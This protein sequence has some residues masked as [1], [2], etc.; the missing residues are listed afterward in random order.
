M[1]EASALGKRTLSP[2]CRVATTRIALLLVVVPSLSPC[3]LLFSCHSPAQYSAPAGPP[4]RPVCP[5]PPPGLYDITAPVRI[6][7]LASQTQFRT[8]RLE[9]CRPRLRSKL[10]ARGWLVRAGLGQGAWGWA[11]AGWLWGS[12]P[13]SNT[14]LGPLQGFASF[15]ALFHFIYDRPHLSTGPFP[16]CCI[17]APGCGVPREAGVLGGRILW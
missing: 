9:N 17:L 4:A 6:V 12:G 13:R 14:L 10:S 3:L 16:C 15:G 11:P 1:K 2:G 7:A 5:G 8:R